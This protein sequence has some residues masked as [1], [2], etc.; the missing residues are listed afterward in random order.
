MS[1]ELLLAVV[2]LAAALAAGFVAVRATR[3]V[4][5]LDHYVATIEGDGAGLLA[6]VAGHGEQLRE[7]RADLLVVHDNTQ[8]LRRMAKDAIAHVGLV[9]YDAFD[10]LAGSMSFSLAMLDERGDGVVVTAIA[11]RSDS[12]MYAKAVAGGRCQQDMTDEERLAV[13]RAV[14]GNVDAL[15]TAPARVRRG[16]RA[17]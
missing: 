1:I 4:R 6:T 17:S 2:A 15:E 10:D 11:G 13:E 3:R 14:A 16:A 5:A 7:L 12:R 8:L 9:R